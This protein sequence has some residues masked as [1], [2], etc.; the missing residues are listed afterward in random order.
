R[1]PAT[2][3]AGGE[4]A[5]PDQEGQP[6]GQRP[7]GGGRGEPMRQQDRHA[8]EDQERVDPVDKDVGTLPV[9]RDQQRVDEVRPAG[10]QRAQGQDA[11]ASGGGAGVGGAEQAEQQRRGD[12]DDDHGGQQQRVHAA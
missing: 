11:Q 7:P 10:Q 6:L 4:N 8:A 9:A 1:P 5:Q 2:V 12:D 3:P